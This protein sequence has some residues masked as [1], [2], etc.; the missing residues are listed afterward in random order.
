[1]AKP[2]LRPLM[3]ITRSLISSNCA[4]LSWAP[5]KLMYSYISSDKIYTFGNFLKTFA[6]ARNS[7]LLYTEPL[8][9]QGDENMNN[10]VRS[11]NAASNCSAVILYLLSIVVGT[12]F[13]V[14]SPN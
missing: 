6:S 11:D 12:N 10:L 7:S 13:T 1:M 8:G 9:L 3:M 4:M 14:P 2:L 5:T